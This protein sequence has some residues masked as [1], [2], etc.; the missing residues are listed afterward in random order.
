[1]RFWFSRVATRDDALYLIRRCATLFF[2]LAGVQFIFAILPALSSTEAFALAPVP[3]Q[4][5]FDFIAPASAVAMFAALLVVLRSRTAALA[6]FAVSVFV[7]AT[8]YTNGAPQYQIGTLALGILATGAAIRAIQAT[9]AFQKRAAAAALLYDVGKWK[10]VLKNDKQIA[11][12]AN[13]LQPLGD[14]W[15]DE[16][17]RSY[18]AI[19]DK[20]QVGHIVQKIVT[21]ARIEALRARAAA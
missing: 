7:A 5:I 12:L 21:D 19:G 13:N 10:I 3:S 18:L 20:K 2:L 16:F 14:K 4:A 6:L 17:A 9:F 8:A 11:K 15:V 1:M